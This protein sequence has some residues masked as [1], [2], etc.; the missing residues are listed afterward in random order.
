MTAPLIGMTL[1]CLD[2]E[3]TVAFWQQALGYV[4][5]RVHSVEDETFRTLFAPDDQSGLH[6]PTVQQLPDRKTVKNRAHLDLFFEDVEG[7]VR[8]LIGLGATVLR[9]EPLDDDVFRTIVMADP[10][11]HEFCVV[12]R[13]PR[14]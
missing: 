2:L 6:H 10:E 11:G 5:R 14:R 13:S 8:R 9:N 4:E 12:E 1:D 7:E 3:T